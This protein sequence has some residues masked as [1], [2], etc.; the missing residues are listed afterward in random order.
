M[1]SRAATPSTSIPRFPSIVHYIATYWLQEVVWSGI[2]L[3][4]RCSGHIGGA[5]LGEMSSIERGLLVE[6]LLH[7]E[8]VD[9]LHTP[10]ALSHYKGANRSRD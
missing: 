3:K 5:A 6:A 1:V 4:Q 8:E 2:H 7:I 10:P 9:F